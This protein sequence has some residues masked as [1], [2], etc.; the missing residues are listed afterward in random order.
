M[1]Y[2]MSKVER[3]I[4]DWKRT[5]YDPDQANLLPNAQTVLETLGHQGLRLYL[6]GR[7]GSDMDDA[8]DKVGVRPL[9]EAVHFVPR[10]SDGLFRRYIPPTNPE[11]TLAVGDRAQKEVALAKSLGARAIWL[12]AGL[13]QDEL[14]LPG[15]PPDEIIFDIGSLLDSPLLRV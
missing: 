8:I 3:V 2:L 1:L 15:L 9:F 11:T 12:R 5:L 10:K 6:I 4:F 7:G 13:F 14:P